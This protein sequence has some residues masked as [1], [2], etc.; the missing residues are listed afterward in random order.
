L[1][2]ALFR[3]YEQLTQLQMQTIRLMAQQAAQTLQS[4]AGKGEAQSAPA[5]TG[6]MQ[7]A[8]GAKT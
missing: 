2:Q 5:L 8:R 1:N 4:A 7:R 3:G 6:R